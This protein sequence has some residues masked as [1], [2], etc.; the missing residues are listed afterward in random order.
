[1]PAQYMAYDA[2]DGWD[3]DPAACPCAPRTAL[4]CPTLTPDDPVEAPEDPPE[5]PEN[6]PG[7]NDPEPETQTE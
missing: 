2:P 1:V 7:V 6:L 3:G 5:V 4:E